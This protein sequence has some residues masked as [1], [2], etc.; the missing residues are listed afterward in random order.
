MKKEQKAEPL[1]SGGKYWESAV[2]FCLCAILTIGFVF[3]CSGCSAKLS[4]ATWKQHQAE[5]R[6][7]VLTDR[8]YGDSIDDR[9]QP[10]AG[11]WPLEEATHI[12]D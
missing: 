12:V 8:S 5:T 7:R 3:A 4:L 9:A 6:D 10:V 2:I 11:D 1:L